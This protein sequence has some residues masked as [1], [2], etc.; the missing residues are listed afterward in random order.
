[1]KLSDIRTDT[2]VYAVTDRHDTL[3][4]YRAVVLD[5][6]YWAPQYNSGRGPARGYV[7]AYFAPGERK[8]H[9][10]RR[11]ILAVQVGGAGVHAM[12][13]DLD[14]ITNEE[15]VDLAAA[16]AAAIGSGPASL[17]SLPLGVKVRVMRPSDV[18]MTWTEYEA[19]E[20]RRRAAGRRQAEQIA[21]ANRAE[22]EAAA[23][24]RTALGELC[25]PYV[26]RPMTWVQLEQLCETY[27]KAT[28]PL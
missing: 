23:R 2:V 9:S 13:R 27:A 16:A 1:M 11:G 21:A 15:L 6:G 26:S 12:Q 14:A 4:H 22:R 20:T 7:P 5:T 18:K 3:P 8:S 24:M 10:E 19:A 17:P 25:P 28:L